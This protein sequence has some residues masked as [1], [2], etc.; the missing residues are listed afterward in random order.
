MPGPMTLRNF[1]GIYQLVIE[2]VEDLA[3]IDQI[4]PARWAATSAPTRDLHCDAGFLDFVDTDHNGRIRVAHV[5]A[6]RDWLFARL[7]D[8]T[9]ITAKS[10]ELVLAALDLQHEDGEALLHGAQHVIREL[11]LGDRKTLGLEEVRSF[12]A[13]YAKTL[14][15]GDGVVPPEL[16][17]ELDVADFIRDVMKTVGSAPDAS[18]FAGV[19]DAQLSRYLEGSRAYLT[20]KAASKTTPG[21]LPLEEG[22]EAAWA[23]VQALDSKIDEQF[24]RSEFMKQE[25]LSTSALKLSPEE[26]H[27]LRAKDAKGIELYLEASPLAEPDASCVLPINGKVNPAFQEKWDALSRDVLNKLLPGETLLDRAGWKK[28]KSLLAA[29][30]AWVSG[31]PPE[32][33]EAIGDTV[34]ERQLAGPLPDRLRQLMADDSLAS[35]ELGH[36]AT[37]E[38][39]VLYQRWLIEFANNFVNFSAIYD[40]AKIAM[41]EMGSFVVDGRR[42]EF[43]LKVETA[44]RAAHKTVAADS[45]TFLVYAQ[46][47]EADGK[48]PEFEIVA[49]VT[50]GERGR[51]KVGKRGIF[52]DTMNREWDASIVEIVENPISIKEAALSPFRRLQKFIGERIEQLAKSQQSSREQALQTQAATAG[53]TAAGAATAP[54][55]P[56][57]VGPAPATPP[58][59]PAA[60]AGGGLQTLIIGGSLAFAAIGSALAYVVSAISH[61]SPMHLMLAVAAVIA[62]VASISA[63]LGWLKLRRRDMGLLLEA[64]GWAINAQMKITRRVGITFTRKPDFPKGT[65]KDRYDV[66]SKSE[67]AIEQDR[68]SRNRRIV[69]ILVGAL[70][71]GAVG[72]YLWHRHVVAVEAAEEKAAEDARLK[73]A[74]AVK[75]ERDA[76]EAKAVAKAAAEKAAKDAEEMAALK[77]AVHAAALEKAAREAAKEISDKADGGTP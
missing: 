73:K 44:Q 9:G 23:E 38:K 33:F 2:T 6:A 74:A 8:R 20:W 64:S 40:P 62:F 14:R 65:R 63:F 41:V 42:L 13:G 46:I 67:E 49:P 12:R 47:T 69:S 48:P 29:Y 50:S 68:V 56:G 61:T 17:T 7:Q 43:C 27:A 31:K 70:I 51:L 52:I 4:D 55:G 22:T 57:P 26:I 53:T 21:V 75:A 76:E 36:I 24:L 3:K 59:A 16:V 11:S 54:P 71:F 77:A 66:L 58:P 37:L 18:G 39:L 15:N 34:L 1:G 10:D 19:G 25:N 35:K 28:V 30:G 72:T 45:L 32:P 5:L 60:P